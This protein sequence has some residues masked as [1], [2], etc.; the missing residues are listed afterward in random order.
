MPKLNDGVLLQK[1]H[2][3]VHYENLYSTG[4]RTLT[5]G[6]FV[7]LNPWML[8]IQYDI[9]AADL[10]KDLI[11]AKPAGIISTVLHKCYRAIRK[12][13]PSGAPSVNVFLYYH[14]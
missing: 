9:E 11:L 10:E 6:D 2:I 3:L 4:E 7:T 12:L 5:D 13:L 1:E 14:N 8:R